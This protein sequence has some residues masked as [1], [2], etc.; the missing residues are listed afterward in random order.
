MS[1]NYAPSD[2]NG[3]FALNAFFALLVTLA[4]FAVM[5]LMQYLENATKR[6]PNLAVDD[7]SVQPPPPPPEDQ[8][9]PPE[10]EEK[11]KEPELKE[12]P[13]PMTLSQLEMALNPGEGDAVG[14]FGFGDF[15]KDIDALEGMQIFNLSDVDKKPSYL[16]FSKPVYPYS[17]Q[18]SKTRGSVTVEF[19]LTPDGKVHRPRAIKSTHREFEQPAIDAVMRSTW[20]PARKDGKPVACRVRMPLQFT[21]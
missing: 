7:A 2:Q 13:P 3:S 14:D 16:V 17:L 21:P 19:V 18:Q 15:G 1:S 6:P 5:P 12:P 10:E 8:P 20:E 11:K 9:P 4:L